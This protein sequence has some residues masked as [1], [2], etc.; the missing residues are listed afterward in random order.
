MHKIVYLK[1]TNKTTA[2]IERTATKPANGAIIN[3]GFEPSYVSNGF[4]GTY[5]ETNHII[6]LKKV[7]YSF[8]LLF[9]R[10]EMLNMHPFIYIS[11]SD[12]RNSNNVE[13]TVI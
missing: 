3:I 11:F 10:I 8:S 2:R 5:S 12:I 4:E 7:L 13:H 9:I 1:K 6:L